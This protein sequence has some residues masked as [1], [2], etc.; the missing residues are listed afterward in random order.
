MDHT[1]CDDVMIKRSKNL[2]KI[3]AKLLGWKKFEIPDP[4]PVIR[5]GVGWIIQ[6][7]ILGQRME[8]QKDVESSSCACY[9]RISQYN[10]K[11][12]KKRQM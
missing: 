8:G 10:V 6:L 4:E 7:V 12:S 2:G 1:R 3:S 9:P 11:Y 5:S